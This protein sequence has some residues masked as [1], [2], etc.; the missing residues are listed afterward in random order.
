LLQC[1]EAITTGANEFFYLNKANQSEAGEAEHNHRPT[2][3]EALDRRLTT[4]RDSA[5]RVLELESELLSPGHFFI[6]GNHLD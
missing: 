5:G 2:A 3:L 4:V 1:D 6:E